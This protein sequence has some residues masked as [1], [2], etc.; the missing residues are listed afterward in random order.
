MEQEGNASESEGDGDNRHGQEKA[1]EAKQWVKKSE[2]GRTNDTSRRA[3][4][5][6]RRKGQG[7]RTEKGK[8]DMYRRS[9]PSSGRQ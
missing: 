3:M 8:R 6:G 2:T 5:G 7:A 4:G 1:R 9:S